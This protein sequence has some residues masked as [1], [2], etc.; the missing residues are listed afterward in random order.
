MRDPQCEFGGD[1]VLVQS[2]PSPAVRAEQTDMSRAIRELFK[3][4]MRMSVVRNSA[5]SVVINNAWCS[6][7]KI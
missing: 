1:G 2:Q 6:V 4:G 5:P 3:A 7:M